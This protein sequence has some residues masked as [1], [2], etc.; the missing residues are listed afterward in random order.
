MLCRICDRTYITVSEGA[1]INRYVEV[2]YYRLR[3][4]NFAHLRVEM[5]YENDRDRRNYAC[6]GQICIDQTNRSAR[7]KL[8]RGEKRKRRRR[9]CIFEEFLL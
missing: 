9:N 8:P 4:N 3:S 1:E 7:E 2:L 6:A 5:G